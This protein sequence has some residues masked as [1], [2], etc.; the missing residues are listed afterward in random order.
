MRLKIFGAALVAL[1]FVCSCGKYG[2]GPKRRAIEA[3]I[4]SREEIQIATGS[5][6]NVGREAA[7]FFQRLEAAG[8]VRIGEV[9]QGFWDD[10][11]SRTFMEGTRPL[12]VFPTQKLNDLAAN[13]KWKPRSQS[14]ALTSDTI[15]T[16]LE[17]TWDYYAR[18]KL[19]LGPICFGDATTFARSDG[20]CALELMSDYPQYSALEARG[21]ITLNEISLAD[22]PSSAIPSHLSH[23]SIQRAARVALTASGG[24]LAVMDAKNNTATFVFGTYKVEQ[25]TKNTP[26]AS[27]DGIYRLVEGTH[28]F[29]VRPELK[30]VWEK[31][32][33][34]TYRE[35]R[36]RAVYYYNEKGYPGCTN[37]SPK[38]EVATASNGRYTAKDVGPRNADFETANV[39]PTVDDL[40][41]KAIG[42]HDMYAWRVRLGEL[43]LGE[44]LRDED[45]KGALATPG[46]TFRLVL[47]RIEP[48]PERDSAILPDLAS[49]LPGRLRCVLKYSDFDKE[50][51]VVAMDVAPA[52]SEEWSS[53]TVR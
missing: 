50:W 34:S 30:N 43:K 9:P 6:L 25:I 28:R 52:D 45:Y 38:W 13:P 46:E 24:Q 41:A 48:R 18:L 49:L 27:A 44:L 11:A 39:Q 20:F 51:K 1:A 15:T 37:C 2:A 17:S 40:F 3:A 19:F 36:F 8:L 32:G 16:D 21:L 33:Q 14:I 26:I 31:A 7:K 42:G 4:K 12:Q 22:V 53:T 29:D 5:R 23:V 47:A 10:F 35:R